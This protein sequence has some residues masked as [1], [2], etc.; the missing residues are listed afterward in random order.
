[1]PPDIDSATPGRSVGNAPIISMLHPHTAISVTMRRS[2]PARA[3]ATANAAAPAAKR[4]SEAGSSQPSGV[5]AY[6]L[7]NPCTGS[8]PDRRCNQAIAAAP[9]ATAPSPPMTNP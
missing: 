6:S 1:M 4:V 5:N 8:R 3:R 7:I 2:A 9:V